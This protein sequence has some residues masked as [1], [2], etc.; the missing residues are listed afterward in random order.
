VLDYAFFVEEILR[1]LSDGSIPS[2]TL[3]PL[4]LAGESVLSLFY[5]GLTFFPSFA[6][7]LGCPA[8]DSVVDLS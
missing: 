6:T 4:G 5:L 7:V 1:L 8:F 2:P 3:L